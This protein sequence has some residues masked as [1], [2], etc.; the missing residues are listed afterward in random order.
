MIP[1]HATLN[2]KHCKCCVHVARST[3]QR[4]CCEPKTEYRTMNYKTLTE[5]IEEIKEKLPP[6]PPKTSWIYVSPD[7]K[8]FETLGSLL[9]AGYEKSK[10]RRVK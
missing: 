3:I 6:E 5:T 10:G 9:R 4:L 8:E 7:G 1:C 2:H